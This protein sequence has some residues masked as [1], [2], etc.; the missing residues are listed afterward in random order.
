MRKFTIMLFYTAVGLFSIA[1]TAKAQKIYRAKT[2]VADYSQKLNSNENKLLQ[3]VHRKFAAEPFTDVIDFTDAVSDRNNEHGKTLKQ[4]LRDQAMFRINN[5]GG[6]LALEKKYPQSLT[7]ILP[8]KN[9]SLTIDLIQSEILGDNFKVLT[10]KNPAGVEVENGIHYKGVVRGKKSVVSI[11][12]FDRKIEGFISI[13]KLSPIEI[14]KLHGDN[15]DDQHAV[16]SDED[17]LVK[18]NGQFCKTLN[19]PKGELLKS[20][21]GSS[22]LAAADL[23]CVTNFWEC[24]YNL[25]QYYGTTKKVTDFTT[26]LFNTYATIFTDESI[27][28]KLNSVFIWTSQDPYNDDLNTFSAQRTGFGADLAMLLSSTGGGGVAWLNTLCY[29]GDYYHHSF[30]GSILLSTILPITTYSWPVGVTT[31]EVGHNL[32]SPHTHACAW[33]GNNTA[34]DGCGPAAGYDE[35]CN[36]GLPTNGGTVMSYCHLL[37]TGINL[38][39]GFGLQPGNLIRSTVNSCIVATCKP[40]GNS[41]K[42][43]ANLRTSSVT[44]T[45]ATVLWNKVLGATY[46]YVYISADGGATFTLAADYVYGASSRLTGLTANTNYICEV[47]AAC[48]N[49]NSNSSRFSFTTA[50]SFAKEGN[51]TDLKDAAFRVYPNPVT[52]GKFTVSLRKGYEN[53]IVEITN[54]WHQVIAIS[55]TNGSMRSFT[56]PPA[57]GI[58]YIRLINKDELITQKIVVE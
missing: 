21:A 43:P 27:G 2:V 51:I 12:L 30:C 20:A 39:R 48:A 41:C 58:Y 10:D 28:M 11:S 37:G 54:S 56:A 53:A 5:A 36:A 57:K 34:I 42:A 32:G 25:Y 38:T 16:Y 19:P 4:F 8:Y 7:I 44:K 33:N 1:Y 6:L 14:T 55:K 35:G 49:G 22:S 31:H 3:Q 46:Y 17:L 47:W 40:V 23:V 50:A 9:Q 15:T 26:A 24:A 29:S 52:G 18:G 45:A 13:D